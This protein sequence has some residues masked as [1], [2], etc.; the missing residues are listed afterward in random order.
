MILRVPE[1]YNEFEC[2]ADKCTD[3]CCRGWE[4]DVDE[5]GTRLF[6]LWNHGHEGEREGGITEIHRQLH[7]LGGYLSRAKGGDAVV[8]HLP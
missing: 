5:E 4:V 3:S 2:I 1:Y 6:G 8:L 7:T